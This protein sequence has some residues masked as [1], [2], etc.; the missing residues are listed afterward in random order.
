[1]KECRVCKEYKI[2][3]QFP[4]NNKTWDGRSSQCKSCL[5]LK[6]RGLTSSRRKASVKRCYNVS[7]E[8]IDQLYTDQEGKCV[9]CGVFKPYHGG[10]GAGGLVIDHDHKTGKIRGLLCTHCNVMIGMAKENLDILRKAQ[11][12]LIK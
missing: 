8:F 5:N 11:E 3:S 4:K 9:I 2:P 10:R 7:L 12:Y 1:M 6:N